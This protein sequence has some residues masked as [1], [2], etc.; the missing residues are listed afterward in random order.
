VQLPL[1]AIAAGALGLPFQATSAS[2]AFVQQGEK[3]VAEGEV[4]EGGVGSSV[5]LSADGNTALIA[6]RGAC[7]LITGLEA[8]WQ[9]AAREFTRSGET[10]TQQGEEITGSG[11]VAGTFPN[12][13]VEFGGSVALSSEATTALIGGPLDNGNIGAAWVFVQ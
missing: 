3:L 11:E 10:W 12:G 13:S 2:A 5:A 9:G 7:S 6:R 8:C 1:A 4:G